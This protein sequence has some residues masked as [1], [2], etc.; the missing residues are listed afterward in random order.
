MA[1]SASVTSKSARGIA[2]T[3]W[4]CGDGRRPAGPVMADLASA[5]SIARS[6]QEPDDEA[7]LHKHVVE[8]RADFGGF[9]AVAPHGDG[10]G[11]RPTGPATADSASVASTAKHTRSGQEFIDE[12]ML[13]K[14]VQ[15]SHEVEC[16]GGRRPMGPAMA[17]SASAASIATGEAPK[18]EGTNFHAPDLPNQV[19]LCI[20]SVW[21]ASMF[22]R[23][24]SGRS[25]HHL[26]L[27]T[28][29]FPGRSRSH[30]TASS[31]VPTRTWAM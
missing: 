7:R 8:V 20:G 16:G 4:Q 3:S 11:H 22:E 24:A 5:A 19:M 14:H 29:R 27:I 12:A 23:W 10:C 31:R 9:C 26:D 13:H 28:R 18:Q 21:D 30:L 1:D 6:G 25:S 2:S 15:G 17:D